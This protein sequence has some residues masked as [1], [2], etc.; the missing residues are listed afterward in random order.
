MKDF[1]NV[2]S[3]YQLGGTLTVPTGSTVTGA[4]TAASPFMNNNVHSYHP[5]SPGGNL[6]ISMAGPLSTFTFTIKFS[7]GSN[8]NWSSQRIHLT[9]MLFKGAICAGP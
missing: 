5:D 9:N 8:Q 1:L 4:G 7:N 6:M 3:F 2:M